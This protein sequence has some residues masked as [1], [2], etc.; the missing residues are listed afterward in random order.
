MLKSISYDIT[1]HKVLT[2]S[3][4]SVP[5][6]KRVKEE[7]NRNFFGLRFFI[8][9]HLNA[10]RELI[11]SLTMGYMYGPDYKEGWFSIMLRII[12]LAFPGISAHCPTN[13]VN[14]VRLGRESSIQMSSF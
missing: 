8:P 14:S 10:V 1:S 2:F 5:Y 9:K 13:Y 11:K 3:F 12:G 6:S 4:S 7:P